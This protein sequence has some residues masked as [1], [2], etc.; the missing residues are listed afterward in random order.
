MM[1]KKRKE[2][3][4]TDSYRHKFSLGRKGL[5][6]CLV[7]CNLDHMDIPFRAESLLFIFRHM[8]T[9]RA[10]SSGRCMN[11]ELRVGMSP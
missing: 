11:K 1:S 10:M 5:F 8:E 3:C 2:T 6:C 7:S 9:D 4:L